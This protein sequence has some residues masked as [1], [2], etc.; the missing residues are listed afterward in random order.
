MLLS[1]LRS[2]VMHLQV[3]LHLFHLLEKEAIALSSTIQSQAVG[4]L[5]SLLSPVVIP[6]T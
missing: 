3:I 2:E 4:I 1:S 5:V 6:T